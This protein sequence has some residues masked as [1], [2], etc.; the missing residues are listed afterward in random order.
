MGDQ[1]TNDNLPE[2]AIDAP[3]AHNIPAELMELSILLDTGDAATTAEEAR[4]LKQYAE[5]SGS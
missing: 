5:E 3:D 2:D 4:K 1:P